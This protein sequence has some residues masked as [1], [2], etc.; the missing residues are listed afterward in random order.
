MK[1][2]RDFRIFDQVKNPDGTDI[3]NPC[4]EFR[5][6]PEGPVSQIHSPHLLPGAPG[7][8]PDLSRSVQLLKKEWGAESNGKLPYLFI[9][10]KTVTL[11]LQFAVEDLPLDRTAALVHDF[12]VNDLPLGRILWWYF[13]GVE[14][15]IEKS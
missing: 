6:S 14:Y 8:F 12:A 11:V 3:F 1:G 4:G 10:S 13:Y 7:I 15:T 2:D 5:W 9:P